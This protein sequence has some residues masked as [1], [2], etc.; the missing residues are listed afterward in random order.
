MT[1]VRNGNLGCFR[2]EYAGCSHWKSFGWLGKIL[3]AFAGLFLATKRPANAEDDFALQLLGA[4]A[5]HTS[6]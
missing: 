5:L 3:I 6:A 4:S 2:R 1:R